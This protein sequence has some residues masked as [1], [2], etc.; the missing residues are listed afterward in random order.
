M[1][2]LRQL[3]SVALLPFTV[4]VVIPSWIAR[5][6]AASFKL[7]HSVADVVAFA[8]GCLSIAVGLVLF[9]SSFFLFWTRGR[10]TLAPW[11]P[12][13]HFVVSGPYR[14]VRNPMI[15]GVILLLAGEAL[16]LQSR[17][18][19]E[20]AGAFAVI[21]LIYIPLLEEPMLEARFGDAYRAYKRNVR[22]FVP[23]IS[24]WRPNGH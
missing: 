4:A 11:D 15:S 8:A 6:A 7:P 3:V 14:Y 19:G 12:P 20:W 21:N 23:R 24:P 2:L 17:A 5:A 18:L 16:L 13:R 9:A 10:G 22:M 1:M